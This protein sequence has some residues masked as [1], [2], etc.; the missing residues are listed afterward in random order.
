MVLSRII[1]VQERAQLLE[2]LDGSS[3]QVSFF[4]PHAEPLM[5]LLVYCNPSKYTSA[6]SKG[7]SDQ[8][9]G[10]CKQVSAGGSLSNSI[11]G[12]ARLGMANSCLT[13]NGPL[14]IAM[15]SVA[16]SDA[17]VGCQLVPAFFDPKPAA[18]WQLRG[19]LVISCGNPDA[20]C[21]ASMMRKV[22]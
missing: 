4:H 19:D 10:P 22:L 15:L 18:D 17:Q 21:L 20:T 1:D 7:V 9:S 3:Y 12:V 13:S 14:R 8:Q 2:A 11:V 6:G 16:G 5:L